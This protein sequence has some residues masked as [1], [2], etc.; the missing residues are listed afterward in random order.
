MFKSLPSSP[1]NNTKIN[2][3]RLNNIRKKSYYSRPNENLSQPDKIKDEDCDEGDFDIWN[4]EEKL[5][6]G[7]NKC[8]LI[9]LLELIKY[10][11]ET[12]D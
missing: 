8:P 12:Y 7:K 11:S 2:I 5:P 6:V 10:R 1:K 3:L 4:G 9:S